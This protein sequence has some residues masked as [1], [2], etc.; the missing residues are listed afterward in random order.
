MEKVFTNIIRLILPIIILSFSFFTTHAQNGEIIDNPELF[1][2]EFMGGEE[3][4]EYEIFPEGG[5]YVRGTRVTIIAKANEGYYFTAWNVNG[6]GEG[7]KISFI[8]QTDLKLRATFKKSAI[9]HEYLE[10]VDLTKVKMFPNPVVDVMNITGI[11]GPIEISI[12]SV[13][14]QKLKS[15]K[16]NQYYDKKVDLADLPKGNYFISISRYCAPVTTKQI[17]KL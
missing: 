16:V 15:M 11:E 8:I 2:V 9:D 12:T 6:I 3:N 17:V 1:E 13:S 10:P 14:G 7:Q 4:G 5:K